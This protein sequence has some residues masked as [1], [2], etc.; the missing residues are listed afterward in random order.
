MKQLIV[1][2][3]QRIVGECVFDL[4]GATFLVGPNSSGK[5]VVKDALAVFLALKKGRAALTK[6]LSE[7]CS[8]LTPVHSSGPNLDDSSYRPGYVQLSDWCTKS[9]ILTAKE[10]DEIG[11]DD[12]FDLN[13]S[14]GSYENPAVGCYLRGEVDFI[15]NA[16]EN[17]S[18]SFFEDVNVTDILH[19]LDE[20]CDFNFATEEYFE[21]LNRLLKRMQS[22]ISDQGNASPPLLYTLGIESSIEGSQR[23]F[24]EI[25]DRLLFSI[26]CNDPSF[27]YSPHF[28]HL[29]FNVLRLI[30]P[31]VS[32]VEFDDSQEYQNIVEIH[33][34]NDGKRVFIEQSSLLY[35]TSYLERNSRFY[36]EKSG[37][38]ISNCID[39]P[40]DLGFC[41]AVKFDSSYGLSNCL[42]NDYSNA[43]TRFRSNRIQDLVS[44]LIG[45]FGLLADRFQF[46]VIVSGDRKLPARDDLVQYFHLL[47]PESPLF[48]P[49]IG[50][51]EGVKDSVDRFYR[52]FY[53]STNS[54]DYIRSL[55]IEEF[56]RLPFVNEFYWSQK[57]VTGVLSS[58]EEQRL[59]KLA[60]KQK[61]PSKIDQVNALLERFADHSPPKFTVEF[62]VVDSPVI[63]K[64][65][66]L[67]KFIRPEATIFEAR[68]LLNDGKRRDVS[69]DSVGSAFG[70]LFPV[71]AAISVTGPNSS[72][73]LEQ[74]EL[75]LHPKIQGS[76]GDLLFKKFV[77]GANFV[78][79]SH[80]ENLI[81]RFLS[82][83]RRK[84]L[85]LYVTV[86]DDNL[87]LEIPRLRDHA[88]NPLDRGKALT[89]RDA[90]AK[91]DQVYKFFDDIDP[92]F[93]EG[94]AS[95]LGSE[96]DR[97]RFYYFEPLENG[98]TKV[99][100][101]HVSPSGEF[102]EPW[103]N[104]FFEEKVN[105]FAEYLRG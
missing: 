29:D 50:R 36:F 69:F 72:S 1:K 93:F 24:L 16:I 73:L 61:L 99:H 65:A 94:C 13:E 54:P 101:L 4:D 60:S 68:I 41:P 81:L 25:N 102:Y 39:F 71:L 105:D 56:E 38:L 83:L 8:D 3:C 6:A 10:E 14:L 75:H 103:P 79:E 70:Y 91:S 11:F 20:R 23:I 100:G 33:S 74:P 55:L 57:N 34:K 80:S 84:Y 19:Q 92:E 90:L 17:G 59:L 62:N 82:C 32:D 43:N 12:F 97:L 30:S 77:E 2:N 27:R 86:K 35:G 58:I 104:G 76:M 53:K 31:D 18:P 51:E 48:F 49:S 95:P 37:V 87:P 9:R 5:G 78:V 42:K 96:D 85:T 44:K 64:N 66:S 7:L 26:S 46:S 47:Q 40:E 88:Q 67:K 45:L 98:S 63:D 28:I 15:F 89:A 52:D 21:L 22:R